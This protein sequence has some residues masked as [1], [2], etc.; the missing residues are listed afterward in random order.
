[1]ERGA[2]KVTVM[3]TTNFPREPLTIGQ[4]VRRILIS[5]AVLLVLLF[6]VA[7]WNLR[8]Q[9]NAE[10]DRI[11]AAGQPVT[12]VELDQQ[13]R[14]LGGRPDG[15]AELNSALQRVV[16]ISRHLHTNGIPGV[17][18]R[19]HDLPLV[20]Q[21]PIWPPDKAL[22]P[23]F[24]PALQSA[25]N[26]IR[27]SLNELR[28]VLTRTNEAVR[29]PIDLTIGIWTTLPHLAPLKQ[30]AHWQAVRSACELADRDA[31]RA[32]AAIA[33]GLRL[34]RTLEAEPC[35]ISQLVRFLMI[36]TA[37]E[38][39]MH[40]ISFSTLS[41]T[42]AHYLQ[43]ELQFARP[44]KAIYLAM[45]GE[46]CMGLDA[47]HFRP[48]PLTMF[49]VQLGPA[50]EVE[51]GPQFLMLAFRM[52]GLASRDVRF[53]LSTMS[54]VVSTS[55]NRVPNRIALSNNGT[56]FNPRNQGNVSYIL[57]S[58]LLP[59]LDKAFIK[60]ADCLT[61]IAAADTALAV[62]AWRAANAGRIPDSLADLVPEFF[63]E[64]PVDPATEKPLS[65]VS[66]ATGYAI[67][68]SGPLFTV[69]R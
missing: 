3:P 34:S 60:E 38:S 58:M 35:L 2:V 29:F 14:D 26:E 67:H 64:A 52:S 30:T 21:G 44:E 55:T 53:Y 13:F 68:G 49:D 1:L 10:L 27:P 39:I 42:Q 5:G 65:I 24:L 46:R 6:A 37:T 17:T 56:T 51:L 48:Q 45:I 19:L 20:G 23:I 41:P 59:A 61:A 40:L 12:L 63:P 33:D 28:I 9:V 16:A 69:R 50:A 36:R 47:M 4:W 15:S 43:T 8:Q 31:D 25:L 66:A 54:T 18:N 57:S 32:V 62:E 22:D 7:R 11:R